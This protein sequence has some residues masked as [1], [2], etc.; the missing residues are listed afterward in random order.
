M[1]HIY[2]KKEAGLNWMNLLASIIGFIVGIYSII[3]GSYVLFNWEYVLLFLWVFLLYL[4]ILNIK[5]KN[6]SERKNDR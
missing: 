2:K 3:K 4:I 5:I 6:F 1:K